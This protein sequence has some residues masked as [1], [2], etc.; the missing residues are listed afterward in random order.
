MVFK[1]LFVLCVALEF[2]FVPLFLKYS[3]PDKCWKSFG[4]KMVCSALFFASGLLAMKIS[5]HSAEISVY[6]KY[7]L[8]GLFLGWLGDM[9]LHLITDKIWVFG[10]GLF[11]FLGGHIF[12]IVAF[13]KVIE[14]TYPDKGFFEWYEILAVAVLVGVILVYAFVK[15]KQG[16]LA[17]GKIYMIISVVMYAVTISAMLA[18]AFRLCIGEWLWGMT[19][20]KTMAMI[21][22]TVALGAV[23][24]VLSDGSLGIILFAGQKKNRPL[25]I[26]NIATYFV[27]QILLASSIFFINVPVLYGT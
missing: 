10:L 1:T 19:D 14:R 17:A 6:T 3:W 2:V 11:A 23:L 9:F 12:Y 27:A 8:W 7:I 24:F 26:F 16:K 21:F 18:K 25:K 22:V 4:F 20:D 15:K 5:G 13:Q